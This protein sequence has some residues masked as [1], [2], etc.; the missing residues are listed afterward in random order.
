MKTSKNLQ[1]LLVA[2]ILVQS[3]FIFMSFTSKVEKTGE[4]TTQSYRIEKKYYDGDY[5]YV[6]VSNGEAKAFMNR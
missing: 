4:E 3:V 5:F 1:P 2:I 6:L